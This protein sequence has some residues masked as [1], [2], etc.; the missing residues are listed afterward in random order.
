M[1]GMPSPLKSPTTIALRTKSAVERY[2]LKRSGS[3]RPGGRQ[4]VTAR[5]PGAIDHEIIGPGR[6]VLVDLVVRVAGR[7]P[8]AL[9]EQPRPAS[10]PATDGSRRRRHGPARPEAHRSV[11]SIRYESTW[12]AE[13][14]WPC[15]GERTGRSTRPSAGAPESNSRARQAAHAQIRADN[16]QAVRAAGG[17]RHR[18][19]S[20]VSRHSPAATCRR[21]RASR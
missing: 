16:R 14:P 5:L 3:R 13:P 17:R 18:A 1:S 6:K 10:R 20:A 2:L 11:V 7:D 21:S 12:P 9:H 19:R 4:G 8:V 15:D